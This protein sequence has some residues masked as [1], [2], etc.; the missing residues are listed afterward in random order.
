MAWRNYRLPSSGGGKF[1]NKKVT[2]EGETFDSKR[3]ASRWL[4]L[5]MLQRAG[6]ISNLERQKKFVLI[7]AQ[8]EPEITGPRGGKKKGRLLEREV[9]YIADFVYWDEE[10]HEFEVEDTKGVRTPEYII[11]RKLMLWLKGIKIIEV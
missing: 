8:Y 6:R 1:H 3:E 9:A 10:K 4:E 7:P 2:V 5:K 11:K